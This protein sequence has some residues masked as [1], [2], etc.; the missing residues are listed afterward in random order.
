MVELTSAAGL[1][2]PEIEDDGGAVTVRFRHVQFV[3]R[4]R[5][6]AASPADRREEVLALLDSAEDGLTRRE[7]QARLGSGVMGALWGRYRG[8]VGRY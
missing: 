7:I 6:H 2:A 4:R 3:P 5:S 8:V 1:P